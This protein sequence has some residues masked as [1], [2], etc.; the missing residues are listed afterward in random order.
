MSPFIV[1]TTPSISG[2]FW[3][4]LGKSAL[5]C[6]LSRLCRQVIA[7]PG[8]KLSKIQGPEPTGRSA[9]VPS[10][11]ISGGMIHM[12]CEEPASVRNG[13]WGRCS[14]KVIER[15]SPIWKFCTTLSQPAALAEISLKRSCVCWMSSIST[16]RPFSGSTSCHF[17]SSRIVKM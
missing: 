2:M 9:T 8:S 16:E 11:T 10:S 14:V 13:A 4:M 3:E 6:Q 5:R 1:A 7:T 15:S 12:C 17:A